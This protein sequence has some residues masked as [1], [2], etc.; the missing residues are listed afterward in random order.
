[1]IFARSVQLGSNAAATTTFCPDSDSSR[2]GALKVAVD[3]LKILAEER[4]K[5]MKG[6]SLG[7]RSY[8]PTQ[9]GS[10]SPPRRARISK[11]ADLP[12]RDIRRL[13]TLSLIEEHG[14][15][16][17]LTSVGRERYLALPNSG[18]IY[19]AGIPDEFISKMAK[20]MTK[21]RG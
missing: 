16:L 10:L 20:F 13:K 11:P 14:A 5:R 1:M 6:G 12:A 15:G 18:T 2:G 19:E 3:L 17:R 4:E 8:C 7:S 21:A 9:R